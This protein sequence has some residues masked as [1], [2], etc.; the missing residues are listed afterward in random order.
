MNNPPKLGFMSE[1]PYIEDAIGSLIDS[2]ESLR[3]RMTP[4]LLPIPVCPN[5][6]QASPGER[7]EDMSDVRIRMGL[8]RDQVDGVTRMVIALR[9]RVDI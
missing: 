4:V 7:T 1:F 6:N 8:L 5:P 2:V 3:D 9:E